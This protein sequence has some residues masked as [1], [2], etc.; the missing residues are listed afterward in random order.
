MSE[1]TNEQID[2][3]VSTDSTLS[4]TIKNNIT[5]FFEELVELLLPLVNEILDLYPN[6]RV[7]YLSKHGKH[8]VRKKNVKRIAKWFEREVKGKRNED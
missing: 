2:H 7:I 1:N 6:K 3:A 5:T 4:Q 8:R